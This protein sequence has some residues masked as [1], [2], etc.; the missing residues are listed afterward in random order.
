MSIKL[1]RTL[2]FSSKYSTYIRVS[3]VLASI[4]KAQAW[5]TEVKGE[6]QI[7]RPYPLDGR[8]DGHALSSSVLTV[9]LALYPI[10]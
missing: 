1:K 8:A 6:H 10:S 9:Y 5:Q 7:G 2:L 4:T 3:N